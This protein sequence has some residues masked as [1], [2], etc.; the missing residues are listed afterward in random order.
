MSCG[1]S[2]PYNFIDYSIRSGNLRSIEEK[3]KGK[4][5]GERVEILG[6]LIRNGNSILFPLIVKELRD[7][8]ELEQIDLLKIMMVSASFELLKIVLSDP[9]L[10]YENALPAALYEYNETVHP[11]REMV[12]FIWQKMNTYE[13]NSMDIVFKNRYHLL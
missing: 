5:N 13:K 11:T 3:L 12:A 7:L 1:C 4:N 9:D 2:S 6:R 8:G 10:I